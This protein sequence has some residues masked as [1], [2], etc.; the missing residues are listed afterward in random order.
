LHALVRFVGL[1]HVLTSSL[2]ISA[3]AAAQTPSTVLSTPR[4]TVDAAIGEAIEKNLELIA[5]RAGVSIADANVIT[6]GLRPNPVLSV[7]GDHLDWLGTDFDEENGAGPPEYSARIDFLLERGAKRARRLELARQERAIA[8]AEVLDRVRALKLEVQQ[9]FVDLQLGEEQVAVARENAASLQEI[10]TLNE[11]RVRGGEVAE[12]ELLR[13]RIAALQSQQ[14]VRAAELKVRNERRRLERVIGRPPGDDNLEIA[15]VPRPLAIATPPVELRARALQVRP[16]LQLLQRAQARSQ[17][18]I[19]RQLAQGQI[20]WTIG[21]EYRRQDGLAGRGNSL[22]LFFSTPL[23]LFDRN[24]GNVARARQEEVQ[25]ATR[26]QRL[27]QVIASE[28]EGAAAQYTSA[29]ATLSSIETDMLAHAR[30]VRAITDYAYRR[31]EA[32]LIEL[33]DAQRAFNDTMQ[34][35]NEAR[36]E[37]VRSV[38]IVRATVGEDQVR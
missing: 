31:G 2:V 17:A 24:Q 8:E 38:F 15:E 28:V 7:G 37:Y 30:E 20:D 16:D 36:A 9:A 29:Q 1:I 33:L 22:G 11:A 21:A 3:T 25:T 34:A 10:V 6:A 18:E 35:W 23:P 4:L 26:A 13:S 19:R 12:V 27:A 5:V 14:A 32:S